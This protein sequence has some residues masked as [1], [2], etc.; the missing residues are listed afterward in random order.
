MA[1]FGRLMVSGVTGINENT[2][3]LANFNI[4]FSL[5]KVAP[6]Q[7]F[8]HV[9]NSLSTGRK[10]EAEEGHIHQTARRLGVIF[11]PLLPPTPQLIRQ[12]GTRASQIAQSVTV[13]PPETGGL[14][15]KQ[16]GI[17]GASIWAAA[18][19]SSGALQVHLLACILARMWDPADAVSIWEELL[20]KRK[21]E[22][23]ETLQRDGNIS[24][25]AWSEHAALQS[26]TRK[27]LGEWDGSAR[28]W[29]R[30]ADRSPIVI[31]LQNQLDQ[32]VSKQRNQV[33]DREAL[34]SSVMETWKTALT[35]VE[36]L[37]TGSPQEMQ[38]GELLLGLH[39]WHL[40]PDIN[41]LG[42]PDM[43]VAFSDPLVP[44]GGILT[45]GLIRNTESTLSG[46]LHWSLPL[47]HLRYYGDPIERKGKLSG[48]QNRISLPEFMQTIL[49]VLMKLWDVD[50]SA[51][52]ETFKWIRLLYNSVSSAMYSSNESEESGEKRNFLALLSQ[53]IAEFLESKGDQRLLNKRLLNA[54]RV[55]GSR[56]LLGI[57]TAPYFGLSQTHHLFHLLKTQEAKIKFIRDLMR[58][59]SR[60]D[61]D[62]IIRYVNQD[63]G[64]EEYASVFPA[65]R[66]RASKRSRDGRVLK[67]QPIYNRWIHTK[68]KAYDKQKKPDGKVP[69]MHKDTFMGALLG[70]NSGVAPK[71]PSG[72]TVMIALQPAAGTAGDPIDLD[73]DTEV[74]EAQQ[75]F[76]GNEGTPASMTT[77]KTRITRVV[78]IRTQCLEG[79]G[80]DVC[81]IENEPLETLQ[82]Y[83]DIRVIWGK[84]EELSGLEGFER[85]KA[86][87]EWSRPY[88]DVIHFSLLLGDPTDVALFLRMSQQEPEFPEQMEFQILRDIFRDGNVNLDLLPPILFDAVAS[89]SDQFARSLRAIATMHQVYTSLPSATL[90]IKILESNSSLYNADWLPKSTAGPSKRDRQERYWENERT[91][92]RTNK[93]NEAYE[94]DSRMT[95]QFDEAFDSIRA[96]TPPHRNKS[97]LFRMSLR[98][99]QESFQS[100]F[101]DPFELS[102][103]QSF[104]CVLLFDSGSFNIPPSHM[105]EIM[106]IS[107]GNSLFIAAPLLS[108]PAE[109][110]T[111]GP[112]LKHIMGNIGRAGTALLKPPDNPRIRT[113]GVEQ[114]YF[115][116][117]EIWDGQRKDAFQDTSLHLWFT[118]SS[119][120]ISSQ[121]K[122]LG[123][124]DV[125]LYM[126]ESVVSIH[127][128]GTTECGEVREMCLHSTLR[129]PS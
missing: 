39:A 111:K 25:A 55:H 82:M 81:S 60:F 128:R 20:N 32:I 43:L 72:D 80:E 8:L 42:D 50:E 91:G 27:Q 86:K 40:Y 93:E 61:G 115:I 23:K 106:A 108:D 95:D 33:S 83:N 36:R 112:K 68:P 125:D 102:V 22:V 117:G 119:L 49:G 97:A 52:L 45:I 118:G 70:K 56:N 57:C 19:S 5:L 47:A 75:N 122:A 88:G 73:S 26:I 109:S 64:L 28:A 1:A 10:Q 16:A 35:G 103:S 54:G 110:R 4:D 101:M 89:S 129:T 9:G 53:A 79:L 90:A 7:E 6:P 44:K 92:T 13:K 58:R 71:D 87:W 65:P 2:L 24:M 12:Y 63:T 62:L 30:T 66:G 3:A 127:G 67:G 31:V 100:S 121:K 98:T 78:E 113:V 11:E 38:T 21:A 104:S 120:A 17:D 85:D 76:S 124:K 99:L 123:E 126:L 51:T 48:V 29:L 69:I 41:L 96:A 116:S 59:Q 114:W 84:I 37:L 14:F 15:S 105:D 77:E 34:Y 46:G 74:E 18:T 107:S 94:R